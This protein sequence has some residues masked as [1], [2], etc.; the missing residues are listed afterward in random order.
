M[1]MP[2]IYRDP[3]NTGYTPAPGVDK[4]GPLGKPFAVTF[5]HSA[6][7]RA[8][9][10]ARAKELHRAY[11]QEHINRGFGDIGYHASVDDLGRIY[12]LRPLQ[13]KGA[14][15][16]AHNTGNIGIMFHGN[17]MHDK[18]TRAQK[19]TLRWL[20]RGGFHEVW[21]TVSE[22][23]LSLARGHQEWPGHSTNACPGTN[24]MA[25]VRFRRNADL[26]T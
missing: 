26:N 14:H 8:P 22:R 1:S 5:H 2:V 18:L 17:Y 19:A 9:S 23:Q 16:G 24:L 3:A 12:V 21:P 7:P 20:F 6:G 4:F 13:Y 15:V 25:S 10:K 11:Q